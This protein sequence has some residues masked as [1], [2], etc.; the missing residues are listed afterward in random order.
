MANSFV[1]ERVLRIMVLCWIKEFSLAGFDVQRWKPE[2]ICVLL[3]GGVLAIGGCG[4][5]VRP[6]V[7]P[8]RGQLFWADKPAAGAVVFFHPMTDVP[9]SPDAPAATVRPIARVGADGSFEASTYGSKDGAPPG[10]YRLTIMWIKKIG[11][12][13][14]DVQQLLPVEYTDPQKAPLPI[15]EV[16]AESNVLPALKLAP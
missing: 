5:S 7:Y 9:P 8:V 6:K 11:V 12:S 2:F 10:R 1:I 16:K 4:G 14:D 13:D 15:V 3:F